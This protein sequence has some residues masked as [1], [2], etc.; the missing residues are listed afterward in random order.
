MPADTVHTT[1]SRLKWLRAAIGLL[2]ETGVEGVKIMALAKRLGV[3]RSG[4]YWHFH[5]RE[6]LLQ[7]IISHWEATNTGNLE[8]QCEAFAESLNEAMFN[9]YDCWLDAALFDGQLDLAMRAWGRRDADVQARLERADAARITAITAMFRRFGFSNGEA[10]IRAKTVV[11]TQIGYIF[12]HVNEP[13]GARIDRMPDFVGFF[14]GQ[15]PSKAEIGRLRA[16]H[17]LPALD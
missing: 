16:R 12:M 11:Y 6:A 10:E 4:F 8:A 1:I 13:H 17:G 7:A 14:T 9:L 3:A 2:N 15:A 5:D